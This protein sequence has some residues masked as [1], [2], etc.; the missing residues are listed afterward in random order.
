MDIRNIHSGVEVHWVLGH[1]S[2]VGREK[3][4]QMAKTALVAYVTCTLYRLYLMR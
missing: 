1:C 3:V 4:D 2:I